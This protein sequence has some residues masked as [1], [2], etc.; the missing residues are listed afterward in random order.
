MRA[1][2][3]RPDVPVLAI[4]PFKE[5]ARQLVMSWGVYPDF[6]KTG[7]FGLA[8][9]GDA[10]ELSSPVV[11]EAADDFDMVLREACRAALAKGLV[12]DPTDLLVVTAGLPFGTPGAANIIRVVPAAGPSC[13]DGI[14]RV[15]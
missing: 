11:Q 9:D 12:N 4:S 8:T 10:F 15:D 3:K 2:K 6:P 5:T 14:C 13:W 1:S 7:S